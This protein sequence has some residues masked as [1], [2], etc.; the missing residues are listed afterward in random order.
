MNDTRRDDS[1]SDRLV[2]SV[3]GR[4]VSTGD[5]IIRATVSLV[6]VL[7][8]LAGAMNCSHYFPS[9]ILSGINPGNSLLL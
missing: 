2:S 9:T 7:T 1:Q 6:S 3:L 5:D 4:E 8:Q